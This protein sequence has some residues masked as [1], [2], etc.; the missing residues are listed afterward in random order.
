MDEALG[1]DAVTLW[2][3]GTCSVEYP[4]TAEPPAACPI[5]TDERQYVP[6]T[7]QTWTT[8]QERA[9]AGHRTQT[10]P[11]EPDL[12]AVTVDPQVG[13]GQTAYLV[14]TPAGNLLWDPTGYVD[15]AAVDAITPLGGIAAIA[16]SHPHMFGVQVEW[17]RAF[18]G[19]P[20]YVC[21]A[22]K[23][24]LG[25]SDEV[26]R[27]WSDSCEPVPGLTLVQAGGHFRGSAVAHW[28]AGA[29]G[30]GVLLSGDTIAPV[31]DRRW[32]T[33]MRSFPNSIPLS[34]RAV[35][36]VVSRLEPYAYERLYGNFGGI[37]ASDAKEA[38]RRSADRYI[39]WV[40]GDFDADT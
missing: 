36:Q 21:E 15:Q 10:A 9:G 34:A 3:C 13:I 7:G 35:E 38:V 17:S 32:V 29:E 1:E 19:V 12:Y 2:I 16:A 24:W 8:S 27:F 22:D 40:R 30:R 25:R 14:R 11:L 31:T 6:A 28:P 26:V 4:D 23:E 33:F 18:G 20:V 37:V 39:G 5:C